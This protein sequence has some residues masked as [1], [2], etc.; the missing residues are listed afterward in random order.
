MTRSFEIFRPRE[1]FARANAGQVRIKNWDCRS[2]YHA[3][4]SEKMSG[5]S[6]LSTLSAWAVSHFTELVCLKFKNF[7]AVLH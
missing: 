4:T 1:R 6:L 5:L 2:L 7:S 3:G